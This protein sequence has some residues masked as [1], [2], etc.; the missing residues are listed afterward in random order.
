MMYT[1]VKSFINKPLKIEEIINKWVHDNNVILKHLTMEDDIDENGK[2]TG[3]K[4]AYI[5]YEKQVLRS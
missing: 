2:K 5:I 4:I 1:R 3:Y